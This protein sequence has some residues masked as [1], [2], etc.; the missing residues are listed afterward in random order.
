MGVIQLYDLRISD[1]MKMQQELWEINKDKWTA[2][3]P[4]YGRNYL[5]WMVEE[6]GEAISIIKKKG[7]NA[8]MANENVRAAFLEELS[9]ILMYYIEVL[10]RYNITSCEISQAFICKHNQNM[11][12]NYC[13]EYSDMYEK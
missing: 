13:S 6:M 3:E 2:I 9:D 10:R 4:Q 1:M 7:D 8:I 12:R 5:L 11:K